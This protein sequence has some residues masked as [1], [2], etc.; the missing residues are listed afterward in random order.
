[1]PRPVPSSQA[2][3][4]LIDIPATLFDYAGLGVAF[5]EG[6]SLRP[7]MEGRP[8]APRPFARS[9][10]H[11]EAMVADERWKVVVDRQGHPLVIFDRL[12]DPDEHA[13]LASHVASLQATASLIAAARFLEPQGKPAFLAVKAAAGAS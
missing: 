9:E 10:F 2:M 4:S 12:F 5:G 13:N 1:M 11:G 6:K 7:L 3:V 8:D